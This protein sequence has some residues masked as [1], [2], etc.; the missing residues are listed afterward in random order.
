MITVTRQR[1]GCAIAVP[2]RVGKVRVR[3]F[4]E[5]ADH[6]REAINL[7]PL[8]RCSWLRAGPRRHVESATPPVC[9]IY[10]RTELVCR[11]HGSWSDRH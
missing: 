5:K 8:M 10:V 2:N 3:R 7:T 9:P 4:G 1:A 11:R 6:E